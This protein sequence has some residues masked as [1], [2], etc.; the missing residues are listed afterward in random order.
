MAARS[1]LGPTPAEK[2]PALVHGRGEVGSTLAGT[3]LF[4]KR[5]QARRGTPVRSLQI[6]RDGQ[7]AQAAVPDPEDVP[8]RP[9]IRPSAPASI[10]AK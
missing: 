10:L 6:L 4:R 1:A 9:M 5:E 3:P 2:R 8:S 7:G